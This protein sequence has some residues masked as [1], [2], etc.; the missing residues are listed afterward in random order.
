MTKSSIIL[1]NYLTNIHFY[2]KSEIK[3][4]EL[5]IISLTT[6]EIVQERSIT[7]PVS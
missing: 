2:E 7:I 3:K 1:N 4:K 5:A 6:C